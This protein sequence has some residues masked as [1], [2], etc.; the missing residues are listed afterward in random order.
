MIRYTVFP[1]LSV[2][3]RRY[4][5]LTL[6][7]LIESAYQ[8]LLSVFVYLGKGGY[9]QSMH[10]RVLDREKAELFCSDFDEVMMVEQ[11]YLTD[12]ETEKMCKLSQIEWEGEILKCWG[13]FY[14]TLKDVVIHIRNKIIP[15]YEKIERR[16]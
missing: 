7:D 5:Y 11:Y 4:S 3:R 13:E 9:P 10:F 2:S 15:L 6:Y 1:W 12:V 8:E 14:A 16:Y